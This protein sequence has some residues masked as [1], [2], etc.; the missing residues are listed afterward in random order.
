MVNAFAAVGKTSLNTPEPNKHRTNRASQ[1]TRNSSSPTSAWQIPRGVSKG[2]WDYVRAGQIAEGYDQ[3]L[4]GDPLNVID[5]Q[6]INRYL[7]AL[8]SVKSTNQAIDPPIVADFGCG[9]GRTLL[10]LLNSGYRGV[11]IDLSI[12]MLAK[13]KEKFEI[14][15]SDPRNKRQEDLEH[16][17][18]NAP[19]K[20]SGQ[21]DLL[22]LQ[23]NL[24]ELNGLADD[25]IDHGISLFS[26]LGM[27]EKATN[28]ARFLQH[29]RRVIKPDGQFIVHAHNAWFQ[30][31]HPRGVRW[32]ASS[33]W[34]QLRGTGDFG[35][36][37]ATYRGVNQMFI[38]SFR[39]TELKQ[40]LENAGFKKQTWF[41]ILPG[42]TE[43]VEKFPL[44]S[45]L[46]LVGWIVVC[47]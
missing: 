44:A 22:M 17:P 14:N 24:V 9:T 32:A 28:R 35:D 23:A 33:A 11:A 5:R 10:P 42:A 30:V 8:D 27:I 16:L 39:K 47:S 34:S 29:V 40:A 6:I 3:F 25:S 26:T 2:N 43:P 31:R 7:P 45:F 12:P 19:T 1:E 46:R 4:D 37:T 36:R 18:K 38:H 13:L 21:G 20:A 15:F 41:G